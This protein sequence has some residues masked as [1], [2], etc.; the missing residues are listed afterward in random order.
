MERSK[1]EYISQCLQCGRV[2]TSQGSWVYRQ[3]SSTVQDISHTYC[4]TCVQI[5]QERLIAARKFKDWDLTKQVNYLKK[6]LQSQTKK[7]DICSL[8]TYLEEFYCITD[9]QYSGFHEALKAYLVPVVCPKCSREIQDNQHALI[10]GKAL[11]HKSCHHDLSQK[12]NILKENGWHK[13]DKLD[14]YLDMLQVE[15][16]VRHILKYELKKASQLVTGVS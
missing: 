6:D 5:L 8:K 12:L 16:D 7:Y 11:V 4:S 1:N 10:F 14:A 2:K 13:S 15:K 9:E 3:V